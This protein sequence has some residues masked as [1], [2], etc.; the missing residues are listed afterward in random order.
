ML[1]RPVTMARAFRLAVEAGLLARQAGPGARSAQAQATSPL[2]GFLEALA[3][4]YVPLS[5]HAKRVLSSLLSQLRVLTKGQDVPSDRL[6]SELLFFCAQAGDVPATDRSVLARVRRTFG[7]ARHQP[8]SLSASSLG[9]FDPAWVT[10]ALKRVAGAKDGWSA[11]AGGELLRLGGLNE[12]FALVCDSLRRLF[13]QGDALATALADAAQ[14]TV[15]TA[16]APEPSL[17]MEVATS[18]LYMEASLEDGEFDQ[19]DQQPRLQR[20][21]ERIQA[22]GQGQPAQPLET[23]MEDLYRRVSDRHTIG[24]V[25]QELRSTLSEA[26]KHIDQFFRDPQDRTPLASVPA[27]LQSMR[28]VLAVLGLDL[29]A[30]ASVRMRDDVDHLL[31]DSTD[32]DDAAQRGVFDRLA[33]NLGALGFLIDMMGVQP[34]LAKSLFKLDPDTGVLSPVMGR[35]KRALPLTDDPVEAVAQHVQQVQQEEAQAAAGEVAQTLE[36]S[37][38]PLSGCRISWTGWL[39]CRMCRSS[40]NWRTTWRPLKQPWSPPSPLMIWN[41]SPRRASRSPTCCRV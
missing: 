3:G 9:R 38:V 16:S 34:Q 4:K 23:W 30:Q 17:A 26:E 36:R 10:Q 13:T 1:L 21:A 7:L 14:K 5:V 31:L 20:L 24:S 32:L 6:A 15:A 2:T 27:I 40:V 12:Q 18:L 41:R 39:K 35:E 19:P 37:D 11:V 29:A 33:S 25:V 22:V 8:I 28:G